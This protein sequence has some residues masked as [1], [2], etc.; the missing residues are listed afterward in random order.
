MAQRN[1]KNLHKAKEIVLH[2]VH[3]GATETTNIAST[4]K[5]A[6]TCLTAYEIDLLVDKYANKKARR[7]NG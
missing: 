6:R 5:N 7:N 2:L 4:V 3:N 1:I